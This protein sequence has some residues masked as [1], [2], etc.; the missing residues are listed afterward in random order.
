MNRETLDKFSPKLKPCFSCGH[1]KP[2]LYRIRYDQTKQWK[3]VCDGCWEKFSNGNPHYH[4]GG[5]W[6]G[7]AM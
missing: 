5:T 7:S 4:Y 2:R 1:H 6:K 3:F